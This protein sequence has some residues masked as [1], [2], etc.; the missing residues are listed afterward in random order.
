MC[1]NVPSR[2]MSDGFV[3]GT[4]AAIAWG[5]ADVL[6]TYLSRRGGFLRTL[7]LTQA[8]GVVL[9]VVLALALDEVPGP[10]SAQLL[11]LVALGPVAVAAYAG[12]YR[13]LEL[14][15]IAIVSPVVSANGAIVV[16]LAVFVLGESLSTIQALGC[17]F[18]LAFIML[19]AY[20]PSAEPAEGD[21]SGIRLALA[22]SLAFGVY[23]FVLARMSEE[24]GWL[25][26][27]LI[28][29]AV[30]VALVVAVV[31]A[32]PPPARESLARLGLL[33]CTCAGLLDA[34]GYLAF[35]RGAELGEVA[36]TSAAASAYP[37]IPILVGLFALAERVAWHQVAGVGGVLCGMIVLSLG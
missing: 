33:G 22:A 14:G 11:A 25:V 12:F 37:V 27:V 10:S 6:V 31:A 17:C 2:A 8:F 9:L 13:A 32:R 35:N 29:R 34:A 1:G 30:T 4:L 15:P 24:L 36:I 7:L 16:L 23:G 28:A 3:L 5:L 21:G 19:A 18:V 20:E 26:P